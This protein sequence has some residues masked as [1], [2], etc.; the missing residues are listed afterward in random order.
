MYF[1]IKNAKNRIYKNCYIIS[2]WYVSKIED[3]I[4]M[5]CLVKDVADRKAI[6]LDTYF[7]LKN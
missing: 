7:D 6:V 3:R 5:V 4:K 1:T 2:K